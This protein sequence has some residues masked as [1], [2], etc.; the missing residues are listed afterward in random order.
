VAFCSKFDELTL[1]NGRAWTTHIDP[2]GR[3][4]TCG[5]MGSRRSA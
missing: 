1:S 2:T 3:C 4:R 5:S